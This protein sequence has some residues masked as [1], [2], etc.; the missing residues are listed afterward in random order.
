MI[1]TS[2]TLALLINGDNASPKILSWLLAKIA[3]GQR[4]CI[5][6]D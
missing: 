5:Y 4:Q 1:G 3:I 6:G 2:D